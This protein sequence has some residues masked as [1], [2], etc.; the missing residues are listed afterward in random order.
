MGFDAVSLSISAKRARFLDGE[1]VFF[2]KLSE[3]YVI[4][5]EDDFTAS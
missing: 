5:A 2:V 3:D 1:L 4:E